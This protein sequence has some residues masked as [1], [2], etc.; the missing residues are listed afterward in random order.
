MA[1]MEEPPAKRARLDVDA[2][3]SGTLNLDAPGSPMDD[4]DDDFYAEDAPA[5]PTPSAGEQGDRTSSAAAAELASA[6]SPPIPG[7]GLWSEPAAAQATVPAA[8]SPADGEGPED[9][10]LS[11]EESFYNEA[12]PGASLTPNALAVE[13]EPQ[14]SKP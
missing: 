2:P 6:A 13:S 9:G 4:C 14:Q 1:D 10:E 7:L 3:G 8:V 12:K 11:D 5:A